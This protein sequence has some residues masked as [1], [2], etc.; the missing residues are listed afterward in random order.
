MFDEN[1]GS[2]GA[3][4]KMGVYIGQC[5]HVH[6]KF[7]GSDI[8][9]DITLTDIARWRKA[10]MND[11][12]LKKLYKEHGPD[13]CVP[14]LW[15]RSRLGRIKTRSGKRVV[16]AKAVQRAVGVVREHENMLEKWSTAKRVFANATGSTK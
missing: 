5:S 12:E 6:Y 11:E 14:E 10:I 1:L 4:N 7:S 15:L 2:G 16:S 8:P 13:A 3:Y 9:N